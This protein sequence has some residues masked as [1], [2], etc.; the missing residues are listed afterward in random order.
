MSFFDIQHAVC[1]VS[2]LYLHSFIFLV[3]L[4][5]ETSNAFSR[6]QDKSISAKLAEHFP[7]TEQVSMSLPELFSLPRV[8]FMLFNQAE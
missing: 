5:D 8:K 6:T 4:L 3:L 2:F 7:T 1:A